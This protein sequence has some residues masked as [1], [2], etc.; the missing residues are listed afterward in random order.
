MM[1]LPG[2]ITIVYNIIF[3]PAAIDP[4]EFQCKNEH[5]ILLSH[6]CDEILDCP[7]GDDVRNCTTG[8]RNVQYFTTADYCSEDCDM[9]YLPSCST[10]FRAEGGLCP[11]IQKQRAIN[12][13]LEK[14]HP[15]CEQDKSFSEV[16]CDGETCWCVDAM[17]G[18]PVSEGQVGR[19]NC[20]R[21]STP[22]G[23][24]IRVGKSY[25]LEDGCNKW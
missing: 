3:L 7:N 25:T 24:D 16:Q 18:Q 17:S 1:W 10:D 5:C 15:S 22:S 8:L 20:I 13:T 14:F 12:S 4:C 9:C 2:T 19:P 11:A 6:V 23:N 21:C